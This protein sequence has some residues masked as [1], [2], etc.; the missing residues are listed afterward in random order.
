MKIKERSFEKN[1]SG[2]S[3]GDRRKL[4][5]LRILLFLT[6]CFIWGNSLLSG[7][8]SSSLSGPIAKTVYRIAEAAAEFLCG[9]PADG[10]R[11]LTVQQ[12]SFGVRKAAHFTEYAVFGMELWLFAALSRRLSV[13]VFA[14][15]PDRAVL[16]LLPPGILTALIDEGIQR[17]S[18]GR[19]GTLMDVCIDI[20][21]FMTGALVLR[22]LH[23]K[24]K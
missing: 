4:R 22:L 12:V 16:T 14:K 5:L 2:R 8:Q 11:I 3:G 23:R 6:L 19:N 18:A 9:K 10:G 13:G 21:G 7:E 20:A 24:K 17:F 1:H 15:L